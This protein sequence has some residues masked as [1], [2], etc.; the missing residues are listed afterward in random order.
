M[1]E[2]SSILSLPYIQPSQAQKHVTHNEALRILDVLVQLG[3]LTDDQNMPPSAPQDGDRHIVADTPAGGWAGHARDIAVYE[4]GVWRFYAPRMGWRAYVAAT[5]TLVVFDGTDWLELDSA[6]LQE[7]E[8]IGLGM[9]TPLEAPFA[10]KLNAALWTALYAADGGSGSL[11]Q[12]LNKETDTDDAGFVFQSNFE[13][14]ALVGLFGSNDLRLATS[15]DGVNFSDGLIVDNA[16]GI[17]ALP[18][19]PRFKVHTNFDNFCAADTWTKISL[20]TADSNDQAA[21]DATNNLFTAPVTGTYHVGAAVM[22]KQDTSNQARMGGRLVLNGSALINGSEAHVTG[23]HVTLKTTLSVQTLVALSAGD[24]VELQ[25][26]M[27]AQN[28]YAAADHTS[29]WGYLVG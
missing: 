29:C 20:N 11:M 5:E 1:V 23:D 21:F 22:F 28:G 17:V 13:T 24:T 4:N 15:Q 9:T 3:A 25:A 14:R 19:L 18:N 16:T 8:A 12:T 26:I 7:I 27:E 6:E 2:T 10:A